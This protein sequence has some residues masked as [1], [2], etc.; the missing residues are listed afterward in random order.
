MCDHKYSW[1]W[2]CSMCNVHPP[3]VSHI[4]SYRRSYSSQLC[5]PIVGGYSF[6]FEQSWLNK[7]EKERERVL[8]FSLAPHP[9]W[10]SC[11][12][13]NLLWREVTQCV[14]C[15]S[16]GAFISPSIC[17]LCACSHSEELTPFTL[18]P[19]HCHP[20]LCPSAARF[21][22]PLRSQLCPGCL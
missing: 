4:S 7:I 21:P 1:R 17:R 12:G 20:S 15:W 19:P 13:H 22:L 16:E 9:L 18:T 3:A 11:T 5:K 2:A 6:C 10:H 14:P 8:C